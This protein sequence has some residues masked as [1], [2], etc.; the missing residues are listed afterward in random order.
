MKI[1]FLSLILSFII[2][3]DS[4]EVSPSVPD[5]GDPSILGCTDS[6]ACNYNDNAIE[7]DGSCTYAKKNYDCD[8][9]CTVELDCNGKCGGS[10]ENDECG[11]CGGDNSSCA[12]CAGIPN[13]SNVKAL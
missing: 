5:V 11:I 12:D 7:D 10:V 1:I 8:D 6:K 4:I 3:Q 9:N 13:G 2:A